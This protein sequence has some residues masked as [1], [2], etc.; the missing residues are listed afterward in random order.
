MYLM[1]INANLSFFPARLAEIIELSL[2]RGETATDVVFSIHS[3]PN[4]SVLHEEC[5]GGESLPKGDY[6]AV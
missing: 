4:T 3:S 1:I 2:S 6:P 5:V